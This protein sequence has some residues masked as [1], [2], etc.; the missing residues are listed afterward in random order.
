MKKKTT[1]MYKTISG[2]YRAR[3][4]VNGVRISKNFTTMKAAKMWLES[5]IVN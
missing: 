3:K 5:L 4:Y 1:N 2:T